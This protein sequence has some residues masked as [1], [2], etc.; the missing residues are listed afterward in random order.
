MTGF[1]VQSLIKLDSGNEFLIIAN[2]PKLLSVSGCTKFIQN[3][4]IT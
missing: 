2:G 4:T 3:F 1:Y